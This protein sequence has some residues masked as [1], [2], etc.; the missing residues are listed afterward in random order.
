MV[1]AQYIGR[2]DRRSAARTAAQSITAACAIAIA[3][4]GLILL[5]TT[6]LV[7]ALFGRG[8]ATFQSYCEIFLRASGDFYP[9]LRWFNGAGR[10]ARLRQYT[11]LRLFFSGL[12]VINVLFNV[13]FLFVFRM[14][15][16]GLSI[17]MVAS[18]MITAAVMLVYMLRPSDD[19]PLKARHFFQLDMPIQRSVFTVAV[20]V[21]LEQVFF[22]GGRILTQIFIVWFGTMSTAANNGGAPVQQL[23]QNAG[24]D[25]PDGHGYHCGQCIGAGQT[26][27]AK[28]YIKRITV[29]VRGR[30]R[31]YVRAAYHCSAAVS[32]FF[33]AAGRI[34]DMALKLCIINALCTPLVWSAS[35]VTPNGLRAAGDA[36]LPPSWH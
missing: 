20:P 21:C 29:V 5:F 25:A 12:N 26:D 2:R 10:N 36:R 13:L 1:V 8:D 3:I 17:S 27:E 23:C 31:V 32:R 28:R 11:H 30:F 22:H 16:V 35:F 18:R 24:R 7:H 4:S 14:G 15:I 6:P 9:F 33:T 19:Y 34:Y